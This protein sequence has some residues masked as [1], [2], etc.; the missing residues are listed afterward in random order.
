MVHVGYYDPSIGEG[1][2]EH[3]VNFFIAAESPKKVKEKV[4]ELKEFQDK[5][6]HIDGIKELSYV[7]GYK[8]SLSEEKNP[9]K[10]EIL[11]YDDS[12]GL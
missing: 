3:H 9:Q 8:V 2:Y 10:Q 4:L 11:S 7:D 6:M 5:R 1:I 12:K